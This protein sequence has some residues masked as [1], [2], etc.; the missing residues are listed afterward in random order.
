[1]ANCLQNQQFVERWFQCTKS[2]LYYHIFG[3]P[4][5]FLG[6]LKWQELERSS[7][8][9]TSRNSVIL[10]IRHL[11]MKPDVIGEKGKTKKCYYLT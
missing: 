11:L 10:S 6:T 5:G 9:W 3:S 1:M 7:K 4:S 8:H 2:V